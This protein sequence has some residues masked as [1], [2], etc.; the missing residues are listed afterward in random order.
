MRIKIQVN[1][2][3]KAENK[4]VEGTDTLKAE[5]QEQSKDNQNSQENEK[6]EKNEDEKHRPVDLDKE[7]TRK[8]PE[9][10]VKGPGK[11]KQKNTQDGDFIQRQRP[12][13]NT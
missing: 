1:S 10:Y 13:G 5:S 2:D 4:A 7:T 11:A 8:T 9:G 12:R 6:I 3:S